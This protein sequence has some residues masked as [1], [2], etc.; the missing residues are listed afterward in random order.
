MKTS[1]ILDH[2]VSNF[3]QDVQGTMNKAFLTASLVMDRSELIGC[4]I[5]EKY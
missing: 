5:N 1:L 4:D 3:L 2:I